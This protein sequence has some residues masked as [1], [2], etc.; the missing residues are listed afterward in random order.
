MASPFASAAM[1]RAARTALSATSRTCACY[2]LASTPLASAHRRR[3]RRTVPPTLRTD[4]L[5]RRNRY[6]RRRLAHWE[7]PLPLRPQL[8]L[9]SR[10]GCSTCFQERR[11]LDM[12]ACL[13]QLAGACEVDSSIGVS[14]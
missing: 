14:F 4:P 9:H 8:L 13:Q 7:L 10:Y 5:Q 6:L 11:K 3:L 12:A 2:A 1:P